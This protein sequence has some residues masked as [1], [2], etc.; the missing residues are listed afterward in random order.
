[1]SS[2]T[3]PAVLAGGLL[4]GLNPCAFSVLLSFVA[5]A[6]ASVT[7]SS[8]PRRHLW[9]AGGAYVGGM[10]VTYL[11]L[12]L[13]IIAT[14]S[15]FATTHL[16]VRLMGVAVVALGLWMLKDVALP[17]V[18]PALAMPARWHGAVRRALG[19]T[20]TPGLF[21]AGGLVG[22]CEVPCSGAIYMGILALIAREPF[23]PRLSYLVLYNL[24][25]ITP[26]L[27]LLAFVSNRR[28]L[29]RVAHTYLRRK[30]LTRAAV[31]ALTV[32]LGLFILVTA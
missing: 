17:D 23:V 16:P 13:G 19:S 22:L 25:F 10:F 28:I 24:M 11:L 8:D 27:V 15:L 12:G 26:L 32:I 1:V 30:L 21:V 7:L 5:V 9:R 2:V 14:V 6:L 31:G 3:L 20:T 4:D 29:N 18:G